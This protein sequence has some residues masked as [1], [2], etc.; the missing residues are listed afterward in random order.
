MSTPTHQPP[1]P[2]AK[3]DDKQVE[4]RIV[5]HS[6]LFYWWPVWAVGLLMG[7]LTIIDNHRL[8]VVPADT[9]ADRTAQVEVSPGKTESREALIVPR[10]DDKQLHHLVPDKEVNG[11]LPE[12]EQPHLLMAS[13]GT[14]GVIF[15]IIL[16]TVIIITNVPLRGMWSV[17]VIVAGLLMCIILGLAHYEGRSYWEIIIEKLSL[18]DIRIN[19]AGYFFVS[20]IL[21]AIWLIT[22]LFFD[23]QTYMIFTPGQLKVRTEI[24]GGEKAYDTSGM[25]VEKQRSDLFRHWILGLGSG[26]LVVNTTGAGVHHFDLPNVLFIGKKVQAIEDMLREKAVVANR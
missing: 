26:D 19:A 18:L 22:F 24:G 3:P 1:L 20:L 6:N 14:Y 5:S 21:F 9:K 25:T 23:Q 4:I 11:Q 2:A 10:K 16:L 12:P 15:L 7:L 8:A 17:V 13:H